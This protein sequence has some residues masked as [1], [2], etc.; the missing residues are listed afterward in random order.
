MRDGEVD[1]EVGKMSDEYYKDERPDDGSGGGGGGEGPGG[2]GGG[3]SGGSW[4]GGGNSGGGGGGGT[5]PEWG[6]DDPDK[7]DDEPDEP[8]WGHNVVGL[9][10]PYLKT[11]K[12]GYLL[13]D[14]NGFLLTG[15]FQCTLP[16]PLIVEVGDGEEA[17]KHLD[18]VL[19]GL[20]DSRRS[21]R[22]DKNISVNALYGYFSWARPGKFGI[23]M[24]WQ[25]GHYDYAKLNKVRI[26]VYGV[27]LG[28][29]I[30][31]L[32]AW[33]SV[34][35]IEITT[36]YKVYVNN[37]RGRLDGNSIFMDAK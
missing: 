30:I 13:S 5:K 31:P 21:F 4:G 6:G 14:K 25:S 36:D 22:I 26:A 15:S 16:P 29:T 33:K 32:T 17:R 20:T 18:C 8:E 3:G 37:I 10:L 1:C 27:D 35:Q 24:K 2:G 34:V 28:W 11:S 12:S 19:C 9:N 7:P 23:M